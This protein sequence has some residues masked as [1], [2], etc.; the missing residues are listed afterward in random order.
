MEGIA[1]PRPEPVT[2]ESMPSRFFV[3]VIVSFWLATTAWFVS[4]EVAPRWRS[5][6]APPYVIELADEALKNVS[7]NRWQLLWN[8]KDMGEVRT[9]LHYREADDLFELTADSDRLDLANIGP[10]KISAR[11]L[12]N[13]LSVNHDGELR[14][15]HTEVEMETPIGLFSVDVTA[16][17]KAGRIERSCKLS[18]PLLGP[19]EPVLEPVAYR[20]GS[21]LN[22]LHPI[23]RV[24]GLKPGQRWRVPLIDPFGDALK[25]TAAELS[26]V[27]LSQ[28][29][30]EPAAQFLNAEVLAQTQDLEWDGAVHAC[31]VIEYTGDDY[32]GRT[33]VRA[34]DG[35]VLRQEAGTHDEKL[36][37]RRK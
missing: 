31:L 3:L 13:S 9:A 16:V 2:G 23:N 26:G 37:L 7:P 6:D 10:L 12:H 8:D 19:I 35:L 24:G 27:K 15:V 25:A 14:G 28:P 36:V 4:R 20:R 22:P 29:S 34:A 18:S 21:V 33:W 1:V 32:T 11:K 30:S 5:G 17:V